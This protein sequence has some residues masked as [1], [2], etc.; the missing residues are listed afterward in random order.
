MEISRIVQRTRQAILIGDLLREPLLSLQLLLPFFLYKELNASLLEISLLT[1]IHPAIPLLSFYWQRKKQGHFFLRN[2]IILTDLLGCLPFFLTP[3]LDSRMLILASGCYFYF[4]KAGMPSWME[5]LKSNLPENLLTRYFSLGMTASLA[6]S[7]VCGLVWGFCCDLYPQSWR[8][9]FVIAALFSLIATWIRGKTPI[10]PK[11][12]SA[13]P[14]PPSLKQSFSL[15]QN[16]P[17][18][19]KFHLGFII[20]GFGLLLILPLIPSFA[21]DHLNLA[22]KDMSFARLAV[23]PVAFILFSPFWV[24]W[25]EKN[26]I[27]KNSFYIF[28]TIS[29]FP[30]FLI[31]SHNSSFVFYIAYFFYG[32]ALA[33]SRLVWNL[34]GP[35]FAQNQ[36]SSP[37]T[38]INLLMV[39]ARGLLAPALGSLL[40]SFFG[41]QPVFLLGMLLCLTG[42]SWMWVQQKFYHPNKLTD[43][44][45]SL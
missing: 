42:M 35:Y 19:F 21:A 37:Y 16:N 12:I 39:G 31:F 5:I 41:S 6:L 24:K 28:A 27:F 4:Q 1:M 17:P 11:E 33:G 30:L 25:I 10:C 40:Q 26:S 13:P 9:L 7:V 15:L 36:D 18:F 43:R 22:Y 23:Q 29:L 2:N 34:S 14:P 8:Y 20:N 3:F 32:A 38:K 45:I 44:V